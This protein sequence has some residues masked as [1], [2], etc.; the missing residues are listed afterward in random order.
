MPAPVDEIVHLLQVDAP[1]EE[2]ELVLDLA[3]LFR[4]EYRS[5][6]VLSVPPRPMKLP[7]AVQASREGHQTPASESL[8]APRGDGAGWIA[9]FVPSHR[10]TS[11]SSKPAEL[12]KNPTAVQEFGE[13]H[14]T[15]AN[16]TP[17]APDG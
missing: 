16:W 17:V 11:V 13:V 9:Q 5:A 1:A 14:D 7:T 6:R 8:V 10:S 4:Y 15:P 12:P 3:F 2:P